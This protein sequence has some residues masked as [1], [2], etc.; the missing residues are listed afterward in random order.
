M[1]SQNEFANLFKIVIS[2]QFPL[3]IT[4]GEIRE[5]VSGRRR[6]ADDAA[7]ESRSLDKKE[8]EKEN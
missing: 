1:S 7:K 4:M 2:M 5:R 8:K 3:C 6:E